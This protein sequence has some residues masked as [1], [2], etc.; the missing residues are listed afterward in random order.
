MLPLDILR[1]PT[2][3]RQRHR[4]LDIPM[5]IDT[6]RNGVDDHVPDI[7]VLAQLPDLL[8]LSRG[9]VLIDQLL[10]PFYVVGLDDGAEDWEPVLDVERV[11]E[12]V[13]EDSGD[14]DLIAWSCGI[15][16]VAE[17]N[18]VLVAGD[19]S[20]GDGSWGFLYGDLLVVSVDGF[21]GVDGEWTF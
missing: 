6:R 19:S 21:L 5:P 17:E 18:D 14:L 12:P 16:V 2:K 20:W 11:L 1:F 3:H 10:D 8:L 15:D 7:G 13:G 9:E 4:S